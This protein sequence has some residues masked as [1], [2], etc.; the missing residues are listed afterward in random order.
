M[1][2]NILILTK[3]SLLELVKTQISLRVGSTECHIELGLKLTFKNILMQ[4]PK[5]ILQ[6]LQ[7]V[8]SILPSC[9]LLRNFISNKETTNRK[10]NRPSSYRKNAGSANSAEACS[11]R[12]IDALETNMQE[13][14]IN[15][16]TKVTTTMRSSFMLYI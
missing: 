16:F 7:A 8:Y 2:L 6:L 10:I 14:I 11:E 15:A 13:N 1:I 9:L 12:I 5:N 3:F 4:A